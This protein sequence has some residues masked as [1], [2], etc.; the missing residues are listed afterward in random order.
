MS[1]HS[2]TIPN[3]P[4]A[5]TV[6]QNRREFFLPTLFGDQN[7]LVGENAVFTFMRSLSPEDYQGGFWEFQELDGQPLYMVPPDK[8][9][10]R[11]ACDGN[12]FKGEVSADAAG[13]IVTLFALSHLSFQFESERL[14]AAYQRLHEYASG[15]EEATSI[16]GAID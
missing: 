15:H 1:D 6:E 16:F 8:H 11:M 12:G 10:Y 2:T 9:R 14:S 4:A 3:R 5:T 7:F 13:I